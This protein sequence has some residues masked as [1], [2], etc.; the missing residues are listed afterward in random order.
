MQNHLAKTISLTLHYH[1]KIGFG[2]SSCA[3]FPLIARLCTVNNYSILL[4]LTFNYELYG[5]YN[6]K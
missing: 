4:Y 6:C 2:N 5:F 3:D 1:N